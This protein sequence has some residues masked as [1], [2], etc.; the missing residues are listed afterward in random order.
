MDCQVRTPGKTSKHLPNQGRIGFLD[1]DEH[2]AGYVFCT[3]CRNRLGDLQQTLGVNLARMPKHAVMVVLDYNG[4]DGAA[5]WARDNFRNEI[6]GGRLRVY[7]ENTSPRWFHSHAKNVCHRL[8]TSIAPLADAPSDTV[9]V[10]LDADNFLTSDY[11]AFLTSRPWARTTNNGHLQMAYPKGG[12]GGYI[13]RNAVLASSF[14]ALGGYDESMIFGYGYEDVDLVSRARGAG[15][16]TEHHKIPYEDVIETPVTAKANGNANGV[17]LR[18]SNNAHRDIS[19]EN[20]TSRRFT[21]NTGR[22]WGD[23]TVFDDLGHAIRSGLILS[24]VQTAA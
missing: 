17:S 11:L 5:E 4:A 9:L 23:A 3:C 12:N 22:V 16:K 6:N 1:Q 20:M 14:F 24:G 19:N 10:N 8:A 2:M 13:G 7:K 18:V 21:A 15:L